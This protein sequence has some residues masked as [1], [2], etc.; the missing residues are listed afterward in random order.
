MLGHIAKRLRVATRQSE[1]TWRYGYHLPDVVAYRFTSQPTSSPEVSRVVDEINRNGVAR[2]S[3]SALL[4]SDAV[5]KELRTE[6][7][8]LQQA[9][10]SELAAARSAGVEGAHKTFSYEFFDGHPKAGTVRTRFASQ[11]EFRQVA[12]QYLGLRGRLR[13]SNI[14]LTLVSADEA[15]QS[16]TWH[17]DPEDRYIVKIFTLLSEVDSG[18][19]PFH[20]APGSHMKSSNTHLREVD[21][22]GLS[23]DEMTALVPRDRWFV[24][25]GAPGTI[26]FADTR[27]YHKGGLARQHERLVFIGMYLAY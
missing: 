3:V 17:R 18:C 19:G 7:D 8:E 10:A 21:R 24:G 25:T 2:T 16:Q 6:V 13:G 5:Y 20:Y 12:D 4:T 1:T 22:Y 11:P 14:W 9:R 23:D 26:I 27:G 15:R